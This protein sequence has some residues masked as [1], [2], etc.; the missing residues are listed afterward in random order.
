MDSSTKH[1]GARTAWNGPT[2][3]L[4]ED[5]AKCARDSTGG[6][7]RGQCGNAGATTH[8][9]HAARTRRPTGTSSWN[10]QTTWNGVSTAEGKAHQDGTTHETHREG[11]EAGQTWGGG[12]K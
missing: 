5:V 4:G 7:G 3:A 11:R 9:G 6:G 12:D 2:S 10:A 1:G 8:N